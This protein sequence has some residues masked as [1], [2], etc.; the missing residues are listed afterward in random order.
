MPL[1][2]ALLDS[3]WQSPLT[4]SG[5]AVAIGG[6]ERGLAA[7]GHRVTRIRPENGGGHLAA[8]LLFNLELPRRVRQG[9]FDLVV[10]FDWD[11]F[12]VR[13]APGQR[14]AVGLKGIVA[15]EL[16]HER[17]L[18]RALLWLQACLEGRNA[19]RASRVVTTSQYS[20]AVGIRAYRLPAARVAAA[21]EGIDLAE[22]AP[23]A[24]PAPC[25]TILNV[26]RQYPR[27]NTAT[28]LDAV[29]RLAEQVPRVRL[30]VVG[31]GPELPALMARADRLGLRGRVAFLGAV[32]GPALRAE[33]AGAHL[34]CLPSRQEGFGIAF[35]EAMAAGLPVV[36]GDAGAQP[37]VV[38][39]A[40]VLVPPDDA[41]GLADTLGRL[42]ADGAL[43]ARLGA[44]G[45]ARAAEFD[46]PRV[47]H[48]F[49]AAAGIGDN[50][51]H[52]PAPRL[53]A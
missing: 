48:R 46:W 12:L 19:R 16:R 14:Y 30:R 36:A 10:G 34:F 9:A 4:G 25:P 15:D 6:L 42:L 27:K 3:W 18:T 26:A 50:A 21:P 44:A 32:S 45:R 39:R 51:P 8:R 17:G 11:G 52:A 28:L 40:G 37:E 43:R 49:L 33:Y 5:T 29:A 53:P 23:A 35:L 47:A 2:I 1:S 31:D 41:A 38:G 24:C 20:R 13:P 22:W 7:L